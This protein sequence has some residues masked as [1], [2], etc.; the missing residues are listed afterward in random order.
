MIEQIDFNSPVPLYHQLKRILIEYIQK[1]SLEPGEPIP[2]E[3]ELQATYRLSRTTV[4]KCLE[5]LEHDGVIRRQRGKRSVVARPR[6]EEF[7]PRLVGLTEQQ[8]QRGSV[9]RSKVLTCKWINPTKKLISK[10][11]LHNDE[12]VLHMIRLR[13]IDDEPVFFSESFLPESIGLD[14]GDD[15]SGSLFKLLQEK[16][17]IRVQESDTIIE[18]TV[19]KDVEAG[20]LQIQVGAPLLKTTRIHYAEGERPIEYL[21]ELARADRY[22]HQVRLR[23]E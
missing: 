8:E 10:L 5:E 16:C 6:V 17:G 14:V 12:K 1:N 9:V 11:A 18:A 19:A 22:R 23:S 15:F 3:A 2:T 4:R 13:Y 21:R 7:L 20:H